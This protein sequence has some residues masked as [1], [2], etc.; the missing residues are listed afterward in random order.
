M[1]LLKGFVKGI[2][3]KELDRTPLPGCQGMVLLYPNCEEHSADLV[4]LAISELKQLNRPIFVD[5]GMGLIQ[6]A[7]KGSYEAQGCN[8]QC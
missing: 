3:W 2:E 6:L 8:R 5:Y 7:R 4:D 1:V